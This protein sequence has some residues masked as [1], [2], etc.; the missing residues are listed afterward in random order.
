MD[1]QHNFYLAESTDQ[2]IEIVSKLAE[3]DTKIK[4]ISI[5]T[6]ATPTTY[7]V[8]VTRHPLVVGDAPLG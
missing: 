3:S 6:Q 8:S 1:P 5:H 4:E 2:L 7:F